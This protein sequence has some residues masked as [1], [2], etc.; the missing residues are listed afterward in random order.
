MTVYGP[1][2]IFEFAVIGGGLFGSAAARHLVS[3]GHD[4]VL[5][6]PPEPADRS[7][8][9]GV[10]AS[11]YDEARITRVLDSDP[12]WSDLARASH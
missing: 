5:L 3:D 8:H 11:H 6:A 4:V 2:H 1:N 7:E 12:L 10:F 9:D